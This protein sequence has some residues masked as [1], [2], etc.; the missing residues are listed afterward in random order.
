MRETLTADELVDQPG[1]IPE[2]AESQAAVRRAQ[3]ALAEIE[4][5]RTFDERRDAEERCAQQLNQWTHDDQAAA[6]AADHHTDGRA[7]AS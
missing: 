5:R 7:A 2:A 1:R 3:A 6:E 4:Q